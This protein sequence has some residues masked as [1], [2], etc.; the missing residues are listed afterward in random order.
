MDEKFWRAKRPTQLSPT[1]P[2]PIIL[3][4]PF[5]DE[6]VTAAL[7][8]KMKWAMAD[9][10]TEVVAGANRTIAVKSGPRTAAEA[11]SNLRTFKR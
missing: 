4:W 10:D 11:I 3:D 8:E 5:E 1:G 7:L 9:N 2:E 6:Y